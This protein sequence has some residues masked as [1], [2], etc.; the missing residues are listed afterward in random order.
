[1]ATSQQAPGAGAD[2][3]SVLAHLYAF[4]RSQMPPTTRWENEQDRWH[5]L[6]FAAIVETSGLSVSQ[7]RRVTNGLIELNLLDMG[8]LAAAGKSGDM[9]AK[10]PAIA[11][12]LRVAGAAQASIQNTITVLVDLANGIQKSFGKVQKLLRSAAEQLL[13]TLN[14]SV[15]IRSI[16]DAQKG[17]ILTL[18]LQNV[19]EM[20]LS[21]TSGDPAIAAFCQDHGISV[22]DFVDIAD[23]ADLNLP[24]LDSY[25]RL[26]AN[27]A[28]VSAGK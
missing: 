22:K 3:K 19:A 16:D 10:L 15:H 2:A 17:R 18:W 25:I 8:T 26:H 12:S 1:M 4:Y 24:I 7:S 13:N 28:A 5:E 11:E 20:P 23:E 9:V 27:Y 21:M 6:A 14:K